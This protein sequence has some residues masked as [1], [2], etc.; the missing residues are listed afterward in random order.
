[1]IGF[2]GGEAGDVV[3]RETEGRSM[4]HCFLERGSERGFVACFCGCDWMS[5]AVLR[6]S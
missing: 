6:E 4:V 1:M 2:C 3:A 5:G